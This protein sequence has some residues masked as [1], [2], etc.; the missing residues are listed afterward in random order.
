MEECTG[1]QIQ[2]FV[3]TYA[4]DHS[5]TNNVLLQ[6]PRVS[7]CMSYRTR[8]ASSGE[9]AGSISAFVPYTKTTVS[10]LQSRT[11]PT[12]VIWLSLAHQIF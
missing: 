10:P 11:E 8:T 4:V 5:F 9:E 6:T 1:V 12:V 3:T 2:I 7:L